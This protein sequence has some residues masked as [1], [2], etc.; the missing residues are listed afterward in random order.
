VTPEE[1]LLVG[2][3]RVNDY[4]G[5]RAVGL[6]AVLFDPRGSEASVWWISD[7]RQLGDV[8]AALS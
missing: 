6:H 8:I 5:A 1:I 4:D 2:D 7:L 3:D